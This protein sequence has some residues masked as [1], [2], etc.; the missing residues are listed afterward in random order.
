MDKGSDFISEA[1]RLYLSG[2]TD[3]ANVIRLQNTNAFDNSNIQ[4][5]L[6]S[7]RKSLEEDLS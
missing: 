6:T 4:T 3:E 1:E 7:P 5:A 2:K